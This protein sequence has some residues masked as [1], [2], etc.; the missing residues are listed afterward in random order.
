MD[1][2]FFQVSYYAVE[3]SGVLDLKFKRHTADNLREAMKTLLA[4]N[5]VHFKKILAAISDNP[6]VMLKFRRDFVTEFP[7]IISVP[8]SLHAFIL[9]IKDICAEQSF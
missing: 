9:M 4:Q 2:L 1:G 8:C 3:F 6:P 5:K 7:W